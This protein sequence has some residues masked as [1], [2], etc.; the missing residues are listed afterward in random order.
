MSILIKLLAKYNIIYSLGLSWLLFRTKHVQKMLIYLKSHTSI[1][2]EIMLRQDVA[3]F[4][5]TWGPYFHYDKATNV[6]G[7][8]V[9]LYLFA[10]KPY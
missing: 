8:S 9:A 10:S 7:Q 4:Q 5:F 6:C 1:R 3:L 2:A